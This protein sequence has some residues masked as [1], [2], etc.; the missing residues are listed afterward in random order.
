[1]PEM[2]DK[3]QWLPRLICLLLI[4]A[5]G[6][7]YQTRA[8]AWQAQRADNLSALEAAEAHNEEVLAEEARREAELQR[9]ESGSEAEAPEETQP[10]MYQDGSF[11]GTGTGFGGEIVVTVEIV[12]D[13][14]T[15]ITIDEASGEDAVYLSTAADILEDILSAQSADVD[16]VSGA[17][18]SS[19]GIRDAVRDALE[20]ARAEA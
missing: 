3:Y 13:E 7:A 4:A 11:T 8:W 1:M 2:Q 5:M 10:R 19:T 20:Q 12:A 9:A 16:T 6:A 18:F 17:T 14:I 15:N